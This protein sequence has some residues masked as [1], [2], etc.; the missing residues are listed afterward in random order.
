M[1]NLKVS[2]TTLEYSALVLSAIVMIVSFF[3][4]LQTKES[5]KNYADA[6][7]HI[8]TL[9]LIDKE[10]DGFFHERLQALNYD[11]LEQKTKAFEDE[12]SL[13]KAHLDT[14]ESSG[15]LHELFTRI[16]QHYNAKKELLESYKSLNA[17]NNNSLRYLY[18]LNKELA[19]QHTNTHT[20]KLN[21]ALM[22]LSS[23]EISD[24]L[25]TEEL[26]QLLSSL[27][28]ADF[29]TF[30]RDDFDLFTRHAMLIIT[31]TR[32]L[33]K[34]AE[35][36]TTNPL[37]QALD[38]INTKLKANEENIEQQRNA[39]AVLLATSSLILISLLSWA[40]MLDQHH[41]RQL[42]R[43][44]HALDGSSNAVLIINLHHQVLYANP[45]FIK[46]SGYTPEEL[47]ASSSAPWLSPLLSQEKVERI[48]ETLKQEG[49]WHGILKNQSKDGRFY[50]ERVTASLIHEKDESYYL[51]IKLNITRLIKQQRRLKNYNSELEKRVATELA[52]NRE[53]DVMLIRQSRLA[54]MGEMIGNIAHQWR[55]PLN[56]VGLTI[57]EIADAYQ[58]GELTPEHLKEQVAKGMRLIGQMSTTIDDFRNF[59]SPNKQA[60]LFDVAERIQDALS[61]IKAALDANHIT[62]KTSL[63]DKVMVQ[64]YSNEFVQVI[65]NIIT[66]AKDAFAN[67]HQDERTITI[68]LDKEGKWAR[69]IIQDNAGGIPEEIID[70]I[71]DPY[72]TTKE[73]GKGTGI[74]LYMSKM[75]IEKNMGGVLEAD[76]VDGGARFTIKL[77]LAQEVESSNSSTSR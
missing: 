46:S 60:V 66:N 70:K 73:E 10:L 5:M 14:I 21:I 6:Q 38:A 74:G 25:I 13:F 41:R 67:S 24:T 53:K 58:Y 28:H 3:Y 8:A 7:E 69:T 44:K 48:L 65:L 54:A 52:K 56:A 35:K 76:N 33:E 32:T 45:A 51:I 9:K 59:F 68:T 37:L 42:A 49:H 39:I 50:Y 71:F 16:Q 2:V 29:P 36:Y 72:F 18:D 40:I 15:E 11:I 27:R 47:N 57:Q 23:P 26:Q 43:F 4:Y 1:K 34:I 30:K 62:I 12:L 75:I 17:I 77:A 31:N 20:A 61:L 64:G 22:L 19:Q 63:M 55:Q